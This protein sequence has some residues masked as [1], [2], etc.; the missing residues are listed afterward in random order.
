MLCVSLADVC[1]A[2]YSGKTYFLAEDR[3]VL[4]M[5]LIVKVP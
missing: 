4:R 5:R 2:V 3:V 1:T